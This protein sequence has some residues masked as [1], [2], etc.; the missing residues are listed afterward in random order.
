MNESFSLLDVV[1]TEQCGED[2][3]LVIESLWFSPLVQSLTSNGH[4]QM[5]GP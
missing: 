4:G 3:G 2:L 5:I 1:K